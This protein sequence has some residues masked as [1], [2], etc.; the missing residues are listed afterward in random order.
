MAVVIDALIVP[1]LMLFATFKF[2]NPLIEVILASAV[3]NTPV[4]VVPDTV[5]LLALMELA[6]VKLVNVPTVVISG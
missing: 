3:L 2:C 6:T 5:R 4:V 1:A